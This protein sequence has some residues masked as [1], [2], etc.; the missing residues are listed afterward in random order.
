[1]T[2][3]HTTRGDFECIMDGPG[4]GPLVL[5]L[6]GFPELNVSWRHQI[7]ALAAAGYRVIAPNQRGY[8][9][10]VKDGSYA[11][12]DLALDLVAMIDA[13]GAQRATVV[14]HDWGGGVAW[15]LAHLHPE[16]VD[17]LVVLNCPPPAVLSHEL[18]T[19]PAQLMKSWYMF[20]FQLPWL[21]ER[22]VAKNMPKTIVAGSY[23]RSVWH[24]EDLAPYAA[25]IADAAD[26]RGPVN[27][28][29]GAFRK[30]WKL[31]GLRPITA[32][33]LI[34]WGTQDRFLGM[35]LIAPQALRRVL[36]YGNEPDIVLIDEAGHFVQNEAP[37]QVNQALLAWLGPPLN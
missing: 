14:G 11:T 25:A 34:I 27:W 3:L 13:A 12:A 30:P 2:I 5:L 18:L 17:R 29:R 19:N 15:T 6:H 24:R 22:F 37:E 32:P 1:M 36:A 8:A 4:D 16:R 23:N 21:P 10:S 35:E 7:P 26:A 33:T 31:R 28:Y 20:F 9:G